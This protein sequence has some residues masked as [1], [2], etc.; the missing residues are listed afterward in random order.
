MLPSAKVM[1]GCL[2]LQ[3]YEMRLVDWWKCTDI[4]Y[5]IAVSIIRGIKST[6]EHKATCQ[7]TSLFRD[8]LDSR[9]F[10][11]VT[12]TRPCLES[13]LFYWQTQ[14]VT[15]TCFYPSPE[16]AKRND[17]HITARKPQS[18][19]RVSTLPH[20]STVSNIVKLSIIIKQ[21]NWNTKHRFQGHSYHRSTAKT[22]LTVP[23]NFK[24][25]TARH[26]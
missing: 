8:M 26:M 11:P 2:R 16:Q 1:T 20:Q 18:V 12:L 3:A 22:V 7:V 23:H 17:R 5:Y 25:A 15:G 19:I 24:C 10:W 9:S 14:D 13:G 21:A 4:L 6:L